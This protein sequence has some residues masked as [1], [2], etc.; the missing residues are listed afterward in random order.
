MLVPALLEG[1]EDIRLIEGVSEALVRLSHRQ[2]EYSDLALSS[3]FSALH[4]GE[5]REGAKIG[6]VNVGVPAIPVVMALLADADQAVG[7]ADQQ[8]RRSCPTV[9]FP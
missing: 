1:L 5:R 9:A 2:D 4:V 6:L 8:I 3:L 7:Y